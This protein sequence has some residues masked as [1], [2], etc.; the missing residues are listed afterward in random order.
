MMMI[1]GQVTIDNLLLPPTNNLMAALSR[2][3]I[4]TFIFSGVDDCIPKSFSNYN[5]KSIVC[6]IDFEQGPSGVFQAY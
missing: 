3:P 2:S 5:P 4:F 1:T 6:N